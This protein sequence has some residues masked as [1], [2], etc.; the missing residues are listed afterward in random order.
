MNILCFFCSFSYG[1]KVIIKGVSNII[2]MVSQLLR[3]STVGI[4]DA[5]VFTKIRDLIPLRV[6]HVILFCFKIY[7]VISRFTF[8]DKGGE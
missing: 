2:E 6:L 8:L 4:L 3:E 7:V 5:T 1:G